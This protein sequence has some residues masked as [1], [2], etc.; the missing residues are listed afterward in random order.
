MRAGNG[1]KWSEKRAVQKGN[2]TDKQRVPACERAKHAK[3]AIDYKTDQNGTINI[4]N[5]YKRLKT[6]KMK[7]EKLKTE[8][9]LHM[10]GL[11]LCIGLYSCEVSNHRDM[12]DM[13]LTVDKPGI[14]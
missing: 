1:T 9:C 13:E 5:K 2:S 4:E 10:I 7:A 11:H 12:R 14:I 3:K 8:Y 6:E